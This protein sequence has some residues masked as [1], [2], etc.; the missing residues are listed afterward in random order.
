M[1]VRQL[2]ASR[3]Q[4]SIGS[5]QTRLSD[6]SSSTGLS[7]ASKL[8]DNLSSDFFNVYTSDNTTKSVAKDNYVAAEAS[9]AEKTVDITTD[10]SGIGSKTV[11][12]HIVTNS[13][14]PI[15]PN[16]T[17]LNNSQFDDIINNACEKYGMD[18]VL[19][20]SVIYAESGFNPNAT[21]KVGAMGLM[22][23]MPGTAAGLGVINAYDPEQ[24]I[25]GGV[26]YLSNMLNSS[27]GDIKLALAK[28]N[29]GPG[30]VSRRGVTDLTTDDS[31]MS[32]LPTSTQ[33]YIERILRYA[34]EA[35]A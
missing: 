35:K 21:S 10:N 14:N 11:P 3:I 34:A 25:D 9:E 32:L 29:C 5:V 12:A 27:D 4:T 18:P 6:I 2:I 16:S 20:K 13:A 26:R 24:N 19:I 33:S 1:D 30:S 8:A 23:L 7:F 22:Q 31:Q 28:Y 17:R 15:T